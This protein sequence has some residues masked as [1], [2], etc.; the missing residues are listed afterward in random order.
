MHAF[1]MAMPTTAACTPS[2]TLAIET[3]PSAKPSEDQG[4][5]SL[6]ST[7]GQA[8]TVA[9]TNGCLTEDSAL[10]FGAW[11]GISAVLSFLTV[12]LTIVSLVLGC[13]FYRMKQTIKV[14]EVP[15]GNNYSAHGG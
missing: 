11:I 3:V 4:T 2:T 6:H 8:I 15:S 1:Y 9:S 13:A 7:V 5:S 14:R 12:A 10:P